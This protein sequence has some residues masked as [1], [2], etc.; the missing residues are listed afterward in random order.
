[1]L[2][3]TLGQ[4]NDRPLGRLY[5]KRSGM[6]R[7]EAIRDAIM[8]YVAACDYSPSIREI[9][10]AVGLRSSSTVHSHL[11]ILRKQG[12]LAKSKPGKPRAI[13]P[14]RYLDLRVRALEL[15]RAMS[16]GSPEAK[17][18]LETLESIFGSQLV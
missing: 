11:A 8:D 5:P 15:A 9:G 3:Q 2:V 14:A 18:L 10:D 16:D 13:V 17:E 7:G 1:M 12:R 6:R 4:L